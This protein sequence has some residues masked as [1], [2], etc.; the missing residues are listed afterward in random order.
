MFNRMDSSMGSLL[1]AISAQYK[2]TH[3]QEYAAGLLGK[4]R[5]H[6]LKSGEPLV[7]PREQVVEFIFKLEGLVAVDVLTTWNLA[8]A[9]EQFYTQCASTVVNSG[10]VQ[11]WWRVMH[12]DIRAEVAPSAESATEAELSASLGEFMAVYMRLRCREVVEKSGIGYDSVGEP[13]H[14][15]ARLKGKRSF[16]AEEADV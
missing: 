5:P 2:Y 10:K 11:G 13:A 1:H 15:R 16:E 6:K 4:V 9:A 12:E 3:C 7:R 8:Q 14:L